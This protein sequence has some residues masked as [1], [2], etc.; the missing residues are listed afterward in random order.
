MISGFPISQVSV[1]FGQVAAMDI[2]GAAPGMRTRGPD[3]YG[4]GTD[5]SVAVKTGCCKVK[6]MLRRLRWSTPPVKEIR[7]FA[8]A[9]SKITSAWQASVALESHGEEAECLS[10][11]CPTRIPRRDGAPVAAVNVVPAN[12]HRIPIRRSR[13]EQHPLL[14][15]GRRD[16]A[17]H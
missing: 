10:L 3:R 12:G 17:R 15:V 14:G 9:I 7:D 2:L 1:R 6:E 4:C 16:A 5:D 8:L 11:R 13:R